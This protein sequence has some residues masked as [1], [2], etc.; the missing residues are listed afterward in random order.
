SYQLPAC[1]STSPSR[2]LAGGDGAR[3]AL[4]GPPPQVP[5][6]PRADASQALD[7]P[8][9]PPTPGEV[10]RLAGEAHHLDLALEQAQRAEQLLG[11]GDRA[12]QVHLAVEEQQGRVDV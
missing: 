12:A 6:E 10:V 4:G 7:A 1:R 9:R 5:G 3:R 2:L 11:L 8:V